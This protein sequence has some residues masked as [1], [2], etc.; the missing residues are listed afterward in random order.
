MGNRDRD[1]IVGCM[2]SFCFVS[3]VIVYAFYI[4]AR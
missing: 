4:A 3:N 1:I 2:Y